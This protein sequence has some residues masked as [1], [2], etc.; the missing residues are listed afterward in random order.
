M[1]STAEGSNP[2]AAGFGIHHRLPISC[3]ESPAFY[4]REIRC[5]FFRRCGL[6][7]HFGARPVGNFISGLR[8]LRRG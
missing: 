5:P 8:I 6:P 3:P 2:L 7:S 4:R 1:L